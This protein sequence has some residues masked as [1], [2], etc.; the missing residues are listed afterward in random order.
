MSGE[1]TVR[2]LREEREAQRIDLRENIR[3]AQGAIAS[4]GFSISDQ[5]TPLEMVEKLLARNADQKKLEDGL[6]ERLKAA[7]EHK[8][9][10]AFALDIAGTFIDDLDKGPYAAESAVVMGK[11]RDAVE[12]PAEGRV[13]EATTERGVECPFHIAVGG[14]NA[15][16]SEENGDWCRC[17]HEPR[18]PDFPDHYPDRPPCRLD[19]G[20]LLVKKA[21]AAAPGDDFVGI[22]KAVLGYVKGLKA[23]EEASPESGEAQAIKEVREVGGMYVSHRLRE[24]LDRR[25]ERSGS[26]PG[27]A[28]ATEGDPGG[29]DRL[30]D[31][32]SPR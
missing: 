15:R 30:N 10:M 13:Y 12:M 7:E 14:C 18:N 9:R 23:E 25:K 19:E 16:R 1:E 2:R 5:A 32:E 24:W 31:L 11:V 22:S 28:K 21:E 27:E 20:P 3:E 29:G 17:A 4:A 8:D 26:A 6:R